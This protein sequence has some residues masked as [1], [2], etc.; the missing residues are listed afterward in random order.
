ML[1][2]VATK[3]SVRLFGVCFAPVKLPHFGNFTSV[4]HEKKKGD[5]DPSE[6]IPRK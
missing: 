2:Q 5:R 6:Y 3:A 4:K 1:A